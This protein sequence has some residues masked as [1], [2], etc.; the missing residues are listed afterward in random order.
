MLFVDYSS[1]FNTIVPCRLFTKL[2]DLGL[3]SRLC[4]WVLDFLTGRTQVVRVGRCFSNSITINTGAPQGC[5]L[6]PLLY[7]LYT[8]DCVATHG[9]NTIVKF[10]D[11]TNTSMQSALQTSSNSYRPGLHAESWQSICTTWDSESELVQLWLNGKPSIKKFIGGLVITDPVEQDS[12]GGGFDINQCFVGMMSDV[13]LNFIPGNV[14]NWRALEFE[15]TGRVLV[16]NK[17]TCE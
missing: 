6:S 8:S 16:E 2:R 15:A 11:D 17:L 10:A 4:A 12:H 5:V 14:I 3:N 9:S 7:S 13:H 1:A